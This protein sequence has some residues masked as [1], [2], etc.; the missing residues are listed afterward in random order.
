VL[1][2]AHRSSS[3]MLASQDS[4]YV[5]ITFETVALDTP[6]D[7]AVFLTDAPGKRAGTTCLPLLFIKDFAKIVECG[8]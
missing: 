6:N 1:I 8:D 2:F 5:D 7:V 4:C 3:M